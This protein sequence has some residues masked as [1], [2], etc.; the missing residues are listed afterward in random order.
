MPPKSFDASSSGPSSAGPNASSFDTVRPR[1]SFTD[2]LFPRSV[3]HH[4]Q[5]IGH[6]RCFH[7][8]VREPQIS[9]RHLTP[10]S[11]GLITSACSD[12][13]G[14]DASGGCSFVYKNCTQIPTN[15]RVSFPL[16]ERGSTGKIHQHTSNRA[17][18]RAVIVALRY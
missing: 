17:E 8:L 18:L 13:G 5:Q 9:S 3:S 16:E 11:L 6:R 10:D 7:L 1:F 2:A 12:N 14:S 15:G 4:Y